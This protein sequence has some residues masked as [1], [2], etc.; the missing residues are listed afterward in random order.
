MDQERYYKVDNNLSVEM[1]FPHVVNDNL[2]FSLLENFLLIFCVDAVE[3]FNVVLAVFHHEVRP[4]D[5]NVNLHKRAVLSDNLP[6]F[7]LRTHFLLNCFVID[8]SIFL[9]DQILVFGCVCDKFLR[10]VF[11]QHTLEKFSV[12]KLD[13]RD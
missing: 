6:R 5:D 1:F 8:Y 12:H 2:D 13:Y 3:S 7:I 10:N 4:F 9:I 11:S